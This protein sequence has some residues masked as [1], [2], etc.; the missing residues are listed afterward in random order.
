MQTDLSKLKGIRPKTKALLNSLN[1][2]S[3]EDLWFHLPYRYQDRTKYTAINNFEFGQFHLAKGKIIN[4]EIKFGTRKSMLVMVNDGTGTA[5]LRFFYFSMAQKHFFS[6]SKIVEFYGEARFNNYSWEM[7]HPQTNVLNQSNKTLLEEKLTPVYPTTKGLQQRTLRKVIAQSLTELDSLQDLLPQEYLKQYGL[8]S[9]KDC[10]LTAHTPTPE[11]SKNEIKLARDYLAFEELVAHHFKLKQI[12]QKRKQQPG[13]S[14]NVAGILRNSCLNNLAFSLTKA[15]NRVIA[16]IISDLKKPMPM[17][18]LLQGD[19]GSGKTVVAI[20]AALDCIEANKQCALMAP[21]E[22]LANQHYLTIKQLLQQLDINCVLLVS[23][24]PSKDKNY[25]LQQ[26]SSG[27]TK[28][29]IGTHALIQEAVEFNDLG[30]VI[31]D[32]QH[33]FGVKQRSK[34]VN[35]AN[36]DQPNQLIMTATPI[37]RTLAMSFYS[38]LDYSII[39]ELP[40]KR[41]PVTT[42][43][44]LENRRDAVIARLNNFCSTGKQAYWICPLIDDSEII[45]CQ[46]AIHTHEYLVSKL[47]DLRIGLVHGQIKDKNQIMQDFKS[48]K[49]DVLVA[50][51]VIEV[52][53]DVQNASLMIIDNSERLGLSQLHQLRGRVGRGFDKS[54]CVLLYKQDISNNAKTR[55]KTMCTTSDGFKIAEIDLKLRGPGELLGTQQAGDIKFKLADFSQDQDIIRKISTIKQQLSQVCNHQCQQ[56]LISRWKVPDIGF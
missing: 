16:E 48:K 9:L 14:L 55:I 10:L 4:T 21:T 22:L 35:K 7:I 6:S 26:I 32:E 3:V 17:Q 49:Y 23:K 8:S 25:I 52:G 19:V 39:D 18:R 20:M 51:T 50:T 11:T 38:F 45:Q 46:T 2:K 42:T 44:L 24:M 53:V 54:F 15:Q 43:A 5:T 56:K 29:I 30:L 37:P 27:S 41:T 40:P 13:V 12:K 36:K 34:L 31:I 1:L 47:P 33:R 28:L